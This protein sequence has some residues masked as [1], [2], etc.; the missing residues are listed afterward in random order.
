MNNNRSFDQLCAKDFVARQMDA[1]KTW[2]AARNHPDYA[3]GAEFIENAIV[4]CRAQLVEAREWYE[5]GAW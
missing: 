4:V 1:L 2:E 5:S 3:K